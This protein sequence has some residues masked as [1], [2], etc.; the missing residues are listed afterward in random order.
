MPRLLP[1][2]E[3]TDEEFLRSLEEA[4]PTILCPGEVLIPRPSLDYSAL[5][6]R[7]YTQMSLSIT[8]PKKRKKIKRNLPD[9]F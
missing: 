8:V 9:W 5:A 3:I 4:V 7:L 6:E 2:P 1:Y